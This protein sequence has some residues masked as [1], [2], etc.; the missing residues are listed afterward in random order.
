MDQD[1]TPPQQDN[2]NPGIFTKLNGTIAGITGLL[3]ALGGLAATW[4]RIFPPSQSQAEVSTA[5]QL[6]NAEAVPPDETAAGDEAA[7][8]EDAPE[9]GDPTSFS[10]TMIKGGKVLKI[11][12]DDQAAEW[13]VTEGDEEFGYDDTSSNYPGSYVAV[14]NGNY[15]RWPV[16]GGEVDRSEDKVAWQTYGN[17]DPVAE[18]AAE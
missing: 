2:G 1:P 5:A 8:T 6:T 9:Q 16:E 4:D 3:I 7:A 18:P 12:W 17:V 15:L 14:S 10:G 13:S 11:V